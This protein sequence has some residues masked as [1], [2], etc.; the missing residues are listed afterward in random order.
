MV[1]PK[2]PKNTIGRFIFL[3]YTIERLG[4]YKM[5]LLVL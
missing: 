2:D 1:L 4:L 3:K 5:E